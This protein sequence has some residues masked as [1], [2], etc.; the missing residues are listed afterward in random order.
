[1]KLILDG[2]K[3]LNRDEL[4]QQME[5]VL[6]FPEWYGGNLDALHDCLTELMEELDICI[7][8]FDTLERHLG[9]YAGKLLQVLRDAEASN[10]NIL[11][12]AD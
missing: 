5:A 2:E 12:Q 8:H 10:P 11:V 9:D 6:Q 1:M 4:H 7:L 3:I